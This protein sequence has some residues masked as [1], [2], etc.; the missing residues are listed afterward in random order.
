MDHQKGNCILVQIFMAFSS[1]ELEF[2]ARRLLTAYHA[3][4]K[5]EAV[6][7]GAYV[8]FEYANYADKTQDPIATYGEE[9][10]AFLRRVKDRYGPGDVLRKRMPGGF[11]IP[12]EKAIVAR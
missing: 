4:V 11:K 5:Q 12:E 3:A 2:E 9:N 10:M 6:K 1:A 8:P 7:M